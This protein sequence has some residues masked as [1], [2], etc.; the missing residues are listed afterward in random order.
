MPRVTFEVESTAE[1]LLIVSTRD[2]G[3]RTNRTVPLL[4]A[5]PYRDF[6]LGGSVGRKKARAAAVDHPNL[7]TVHDVGES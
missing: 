4:R 2:A 6:L 1:P 5:I 7:C 3:G